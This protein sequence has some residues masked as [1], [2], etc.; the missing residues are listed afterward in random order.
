MGHGGNTRKAEQLGDERA[1]LMIVVVDRHAAEQDQIPARGFQLRSNDL[2]SLEGISGNLVRLQEHATI[3]APRQRGPNR[4]LRDG[5]T[6]TDDYDLPPGPNLLFT[7]QRLFEREFVIGIQDEFDA[8]FVE[9]FAVGSDFYA[10]LRIRHALD[11]DRDFHEA[12][13]LR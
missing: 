6:E 9:A 2:G 4:L 5:R 8:R 11:A 12:R 13:K 3:S 1:D 7:T 10:R